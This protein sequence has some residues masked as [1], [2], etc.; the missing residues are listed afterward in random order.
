MAYRAPEL[1][2]PKVGEDI[3]TQCDVWSLGCV[4]FAL[5]FGQGFSPFECTFDDQ[6][7]PKVMIYQHP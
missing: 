2:D 5:F 7:K 3:T 1:W 4:L 6:D